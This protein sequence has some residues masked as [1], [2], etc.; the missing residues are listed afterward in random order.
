[1]GSWAAQFLGNLALSSVSQFC[2]IFN[3]EGHDKA[4]SKKIKSFWWAMESL[5]SE[6]TAQKVKDDH[7]SFTSEEA[8]FQFGINTWQL[9]L[10]IIFKINTSY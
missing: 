8:I 1:M 6:H 2:S 5:L 3:N 9:M 7:L 10:H 4:I